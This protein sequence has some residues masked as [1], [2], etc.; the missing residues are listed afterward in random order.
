MPEIT[1]EEDTPLDFKEF[2]SKPYDKNLQDKESIS[3]KITWFKY[4]T[5]KWVLYIAMIAM[6]C[7]VF[8]ELGANYLKIENSLVTSAF[9]AFKLIAMTSIGFILGTNVLK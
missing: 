9:E 4:Q 8:I 6:V 3:D 7:C 2:S 5:W 1:F